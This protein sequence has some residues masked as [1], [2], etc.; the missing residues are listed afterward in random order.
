MKETAKW[1]FW[2]STHLP[3]STLILIE[4]SA[5]A[6][7]PWPREICIKVAFLPNL[8]AVF[9]ISNLGSAPGLR[10]K[11]RGVKGVPSLTENSK[12]KAGGETYLYPISSSISFVHP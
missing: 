1:Q 3:S 2:R 5:I 6:P 12:S 11:M 8:S 10:I 7:Y 4:A 9:S